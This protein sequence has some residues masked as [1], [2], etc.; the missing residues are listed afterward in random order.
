VSRKRF[1]P[2]LLNGALAALA[3][4]ATLSACTNN[5]Y[6]D[7]DDGRK[8]LYASFSE[9]PKSLD[10]AVAYDTVAH[11]ITGQVHDTLLEYS[12]PCAL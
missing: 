10:P 11:E 8:V 4:V 3:L 5:P 6:P 1:W 7:S 2:R 12:S 9:A